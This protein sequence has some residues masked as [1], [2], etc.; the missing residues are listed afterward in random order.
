MGRRASVRSWRT[1]AGR[2]RTSILGSGQQ[3]KQQAAT[4]S[5]RERQLE[6]GD[7]RRRRR[8]PGSP[9]GGPRV[10]RPP[11]LRRIHPKGA[12]PSPRGNFRQ[13]LRGSAMF[14]G[15]GDEEA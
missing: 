7:G 6:A 4:T 14:R 15:C 13:L 1:R 12:R 2:P 11:I 9:R 5:R 8:S 3:Q 10:L